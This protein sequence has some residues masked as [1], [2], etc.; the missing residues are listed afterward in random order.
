MEQV[1]L[2]FEDCAAGETF[3]HAPGRSFHSE[4]VASH[5]RRSLELTPQRHLPETFVVAAATALTT[6][7][8]GRVVAN[9][10]WYDVQLPVQVSVG[11]TIEAEFQPSGDPRLT[12]TARRGHRRGCNTGPQSAWRRGAVLSPYPVGLSSRRRRALRESGGPWV[13]LAAVTARNA[14]A[15]QARATQDASTGPRLLRRGLLAMTAG[16]RY[17][18]IM[19]F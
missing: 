7:T 11:D 1:G 9:L 18:G 15:R 17:T 13:S 19:R 16:P 10:G 14:Q 4:E 2:W 3:V 5:A 6:R 8:F 12:F